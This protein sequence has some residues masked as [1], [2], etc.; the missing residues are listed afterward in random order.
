MKQENT[1][2]P[3]EVARFAKHA[4]H[5][6]DTDGPLK[7]LHD[8]NPVRLDWIQQFIT[9]PGLKVLDIGCGG[10]VLCEG[11]AK[12]GAEVTGL[13][14]E[15]GAIHAA[16]QHAK[17]ENIKKPFYLLSNTDT[18]FRATKACA[19]LSTEDNTCIL[20]PETAALLSLKPGDPVR[21]APF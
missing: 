12:K 7:T 17:A 9:L 11:L 13:D 4:K 2:D 19:T 10:G 14:V 6:W 16:S 20:T 5:W 21:V 18:C 15:K 3:S 8:I 1:V